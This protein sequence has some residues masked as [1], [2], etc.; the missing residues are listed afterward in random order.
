MTVDVEVLKENGRVLLRK[1]RPSQ[2]NGA[3]R[4]N[5]HAL[6]V[7][8]SRS[9]PAN[10]RWLAGL[11]ALDYEAVSRRIA[12]CERPEELNTLLDEI[13]VAQQACARLLAKHYEVRV[14][15]FRLE[16]QAT[17]RL[18]E[19]VI[20]RIPT[21]GGSGRGK[22]IPQRGKLFELDRLGITRKQAYEYR[23]I[24]ELQPAEIDNYVATCRAELRVPT[25]S[26][27][28]TAT[29]K[30]Q[31]LQRNV[32][33]RPWTEDRSGLFG[34]DVIQGEPSPAASAHE[35]IC[36]LCEEDFAAHV[37]ACLKRMSSP[38]RRFI[39]GLSDECLDDFIQ[40][41]YERRGRPAEQRRFIAQLMAEEPDG[42]DTN[43]AAPVN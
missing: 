24:L 33:N 5:G 43:D 29:R 14:K 28:L 17:R 11:Q 30:R 27:L 18:Q 13:K 12:S 19:K 36:Q 2:G 32:R 40:G 23:G 10:K 8:Q 6:V 20:E 7:P 9:Q 41:L 39:R 42:G 31:I 25:R 35:V 22:R 15:L 1:A 3:A 34:C 16:V 4:S 26:G 37:A 21:V 38:Y